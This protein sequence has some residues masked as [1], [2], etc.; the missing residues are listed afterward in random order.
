MRVIGAP[1]NDYF[2]EPR[3]LGCQTALQP[4]VS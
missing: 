3:G 4:N 1:P 2:R